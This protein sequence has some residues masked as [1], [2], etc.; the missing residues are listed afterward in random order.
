MKLQV[1]T[2]L[3]NRYRITA[4]LSQGGFGYTYLADDDLFG[5]KVCIKELF[6]SGRSTRGPNQEVITEDTSDFSFEHFSTRFWEE[7]KQLAAF[8]HPNIVKVKDFFRSNGSTYFVMEY[9]EGETL[10]ANKMKG[11]LKDEQSIFAVMTQLLAA[12]ETVHNAGMLHRD[13]KPDNILIANNNRVVLID[14]G[15]ARDYEEAKTLTQSTILTPGYAPIEQYSNRAKRGAFTDIYALGATLYFLLTGQ[16]PLPATDRYREQLPSPQQLNPSISTQLSSAVMMAMAMEPEDR[17]QTVADL[18]VALLL[19]QGDLSD[20]KE[21]EE[22]DNKIIVNVK[23]Q[24]KEWYKKFLLGVAAASLS[25]LGF[26]ILLSNSNNY[27][28]N[29]KD[30]ESLILHNNYCDCYEALKDK[31]NSLSSETDAASLYSKER[32]VCEELEKKYFTNGELQK[33]YEVLKREG[34]LSKTFDEFVEKC[35]DSAYIDKVYLVVSRDG[36]YTKDKISFLT[37]Y[38]SVSHQPAQLYA[39]Q[40]TCTLR[41]IELISELYERAKQLGYKYEE[42]K[43]EI[44]LYNDQEV[45]DDM[46]EYAEGKGIS[47]NKFGFSIL[48]GKY[49]KDNLNVITLKEAHRLFVETGYDGDFNKFKNLI[50]T[51]SEALQDAHSLFEVDDYLGKLYEWIVTQDVT[52]IDD[53][54]ID[55]FKQKMQDEVYATKTHSWICEIDNTFKNRRPL[56]KFLKKVKFNR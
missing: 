24:K 44:L 16:K 28:S 30:K 38:F 34:Y 3:S 22:L 47:K 29:L 53:L 54:S 7:A 27:T 21:S 23:T 43:F 48:I 8:D 9:I 56:K 37:K 39:S 14:F 41:N 17:F 18:K 13:I 55:Q 51:N 42:K 32:I 10:Q 11:G 20:I 15:S 12:V 45:Y 31:V 26:Y 6:I 46:Y 19:S 50:S 4:F 33:L 49:K 1:Q 40:S 2:L 5:K 25:T 52:F 35:K 36:L